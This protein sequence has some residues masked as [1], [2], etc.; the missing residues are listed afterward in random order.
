MAAGAILLPPGE[1][2][3]LA[4]DSRPARLATGSAELYLR[5]GT[6]QDFVARLGPGDPLLPAL[7][8]GA[9][10]VLVVSAEL[11]LE[12]HAQRRRGHRHVQRLRAP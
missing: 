6:T 3:A 11:T 10:F 7:P 8:D 1:P 9:Q 4:S 5:T 2:V 12:L